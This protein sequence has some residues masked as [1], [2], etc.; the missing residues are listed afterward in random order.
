MLSSL[1][2]RAA[3]SLDSAVI[4]PL[5][6]SIS[7]PSSSDGEDEDGERLKDLPEEGYT[8]LL[9]MLQDKRVTVVRRE[10]GFE[11]RLL[12]RCSRCSVGV[13]YE[14]QSEG[15]SIEEGNWKGKGKEGAYAGRV[16]YLLPGGIMSTEVMAKGLGKDG[17]RIGEEAVSIAREAVAAW[18]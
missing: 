15:G 5:A 17:K 11:K 12:W 8:K 7:R 10:D 16:V 6:S 13:G 4:L 14:I 3:P 2:R 1:P 9:G 18:E